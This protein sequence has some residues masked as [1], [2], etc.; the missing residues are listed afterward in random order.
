MDEPLRARVPNS[1]DDIEALVIQ[2]P[3]EQD[4]LTTSERKQRRDIAV[5]FSVQQILQF[6]IAK[7][8]CHYR[9][10]RKSQEAT[11]MPE[12]QP[13]PEPPS[14][15]DRPPS[16]SGSNHSAVM[17]RLLEETAVMELERRKTDALVHQAD[18]ALRI[19][20]ADNQAV[21]LQLETRRPA[22]LVAA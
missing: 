8:I 5:F 2:V 6:F 9:Q 22:R 1:H 21:L 10:V 15:T 4:D 14:F 20:E 19:A 12:G 18:A 11:G 17:A 3:A 16:P 7:C 13:E